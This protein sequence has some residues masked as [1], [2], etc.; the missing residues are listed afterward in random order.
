MLGLRCYTQAFSGRGEWKLLFVVVHGLLSHCSGFS[1]CRAWALCAEASE[2]A[3][4]ELSI[5]GSWALELWFS[6]CGMCLV[7]LLHVGSSQNKD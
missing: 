5:C 4:C 2:V 3:T 7:G 1:C 6:S